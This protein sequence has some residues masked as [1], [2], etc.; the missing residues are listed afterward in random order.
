M[1]IKNENGV[2]KYYVLLVERFNCKGKDNTDC[3]YRG[4]GL[5]DADDL[6]KNGATKNCI[7][8]FNKIKFS[9]NGIKDFEYVP[10]SSGTLRE[11]SIINYLGNVNS[12][13]TKGI[14]IKAVYL[15]YKIEQQPTGRLPGNKLKRRKMDAD[16]NEIKV[17]AE[18]LVE[19][20]VKA[21]GII[22]ANHG[23]SDY[24]LQYEFRGLQFYLNRYELDKQCLGHMGCELQVMVKLSTSPNFYTLV[25]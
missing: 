12:N 10:G 8:N 3:N 11:S 7:S 13:I 22:Y 6:F 19:A 21:A 15:H 16:F 4:V 20:K 14:K 9:E 2:Y 23:S 18:K 25:K 17:I 24:K 1:L 5:V